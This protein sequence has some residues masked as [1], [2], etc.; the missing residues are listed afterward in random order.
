[1]R[2]SASP[3]CKRA[4]IALFVVIAALIIGAS[5]NSESLSCIG[6][7][8]SNRFSVFVGSCARELSASTFGK[9]AGNVVKKFYGFTVLRLTYLCIPLIVFMV[10]LAFFVDLMRSW[11]RTI[12]LTSFMLIIGGLLYF[13]CGSKFNVP[14]KPVAD[15]RCLTSFH[16][17]DTALGTFFPS[18]GSYGE[19]ETVKESTSSN[20]EFYPQCYPDWPYWAYYI[21]HTLCYAYVLALAGSLFARNFVNMFFF[22]LRCWKWRVLESLS[23]KMP[24]KYR[25]RYV[26]IIWEPD[27]K[28]ISALTAGESEMASK[29]QTTRSFFVFPV[30]NPFARD[31][32][33][34]PVIRNIDRNQGGK[35]LEVSREKPMGLRFVGK[36]LARAEEHWFV[37]A[38]GAQ[39]IALAEEVLS[40]VSGDFG[41]KTGDRSVVSVYVRVDSDAEDD[42][43]YRW[44]TAWSKLRKS[45]DG[46]KAVAD[47]SDHTGEHPNIEINIIRDSSL[48]ASDFLWRHPMFKTPGITVNAFPANQKPSVEGAFRVLLIGCGA[49]GKALFRAMVENAQFPN[50]PLAIDIIDKEASTSLPFR[51][52]LTED[53]DAAKPPEICANGTI[54]G[55][56]RHRAWDVYARDFWDEIEKSAEGQPYNRIVSALPVGLDN[57]RICERIAKIYRSKGV[58]SKVLECDPEE[59]LFAC[60]RSRS[61]S[62]CMK[63]FLNDEKS[64]Q[65][66]DLSGQLS[67]TLFGA[68][69]D[70]YAGASEEIK[71]RD[72]AA[73]FIN[74]KWAREPKDK[75]EFIDFFKKESSRAAAFGFVNLARLLGIAVSQECV[76]TK[77]RIIMAASGNALGKL[78][79]RIEKLSAN[80][81]HTALRFLAETEH[82]RW[83]AFL[84]LR[85]VRP[86]P[87]NTT[88]IKGEIVGMVLQKIEE[89][90][91]RPKKEGE[92]FNSAN[93]RIKPN[94]QDLL[95]SHALLVPYDELRKVDEVFTE[96]HTEAG[97]SWKC[98]LARND[99]STVLETMWEA[100]SN[101]GWT[102]EENKGDEVK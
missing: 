66:A 86:W 83:N 101:T 15:S 82:M 84:L 47:S 12:L 90:K 8:L 14:G 45:E 95:N 52:L 68:V 31:A 11:W 13:Y 77:S 36:W 43:L 27:E 48:V 91:A 98:N 94:Q 44:A 49:Q 5:A 87:C 35:W 81:N 50:T 96:A 3:S 46:D 41:Q 67:S 78:K 28:L 16:A 88:T 54:N 26:R 1:M 93:C 73:V 55:T 39:N 25:H 89:E 34:A 79:R 65:S 33:I 72:S 24:L 17:V 71:V 10:A 56:F 102:C 75:W 40:H 2:E 59:V 18:R 85:G 7:E 22:W 69:E 53:N 30:E 60:I 9:I 64:S 76:S 58:F 38:N 99:E 29:S 4:K 32:S 57:I 19:F 20:G 6:A 42:I 21:F 23:A 80:E 97:I 61:D 63:I 70:I 92:V 74:D 62:E 100:L 37:G 51:E